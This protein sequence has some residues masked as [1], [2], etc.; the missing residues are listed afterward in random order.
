M[1]CVRCES[2]VK[3]ELDKM[4]LSYKTVKSGEILLHNELTQVE[5]ERFNEVLERSGLGVLDDKKSVL[6]EKI[7]NTIIDLVLNSNEKLQIKLSAYLKQT[8]EY[9]YHYLARLFA[10]VNGTSIE[11]Y[12]IMIRIEH[13]KELLMYDN[14]SIAE[15]ADLL[16]FSSSSHLCHQFKKITGLTPNYFRNIMSNKNTN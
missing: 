15:I 5:I 12:F 8:L 7:K 9:D 10:E 2:M 11:H 13:V 16:N 6:V 14:R 3:T 4:G 1:V